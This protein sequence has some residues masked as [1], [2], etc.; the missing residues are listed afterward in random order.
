[1]DDMLW[2]ID[3]A[4]DSMAKTLQRIKKVTNEMQTVSG[5]SVDLIIDTKLEGKELDMKLRHDIF[6]LY[7]DA[8]LF[9]VK[10]ENVKQVFVNM[11]LNPLKNT[12][13][14]ELL[15]ERPDNL[16]DFELQLNR[17]IQKRLEQLPAS[18]DLFAESKHVSIAFNIHLK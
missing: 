17:A 2:S 3:P 4:N 5:V 18:M 6:F 1:M 11:K 7:K 8:I 13:I 12:L 10:N 16:I 9:L 15:S 14:L